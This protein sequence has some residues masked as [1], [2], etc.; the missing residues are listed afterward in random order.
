M[1]S[2]KATLLATVLILGLAIVFGAAAS[3]LTNRTAGAFSAPAQKID[4]QVIYLGTSDQTSSIVAAL[5][6]AS[7]AFIQTDDPRSLARASSGTVVYVD[8]PWYLAHLSN[9]AVNNSLSIVL[10]SGV[11]VVEVLPF[12]QSSTPFLPQL[13]PGVESMT[14]ILKEG[15]VQVSVTFL[16]YGLKVFPTSVGHVQYSV[17]YFVADSSNLSSSAAWFASDSLSW[18]LRETGNTPPPPPSGM[19]SS[20]T[21]IAAPQVVG[22]DNACVSHNANQSYTPQPLLAVGDPCPISGL[23]QSFVKNLYLSWDLCDTQGGLGYITANDNLYVV[24]NSGSNTYNFYVWYLWTNEVPGVL[25]QPSGC[26]SNWYGAD[27]QEQIDAG[28]YSGIYIWCYGPGT[29]TG[30][31]T[32]GVDVGFSAGSSGASASL[33]YSYSYSISDA[34]V[35]DQSNPSQSVNLLHWWTDL[36]EQ[37]SSG[38]NTFN[39]YPAGT[40]AVP[41]GSSTNLKS[42]WQ[43]ARWAQPGWC[44]WFC[45]ETLSSYFQIYFGN[46]SW[47]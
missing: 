9:S 45:G 1:N 5:K 25:P 11:P 29:T 22:I 7:Y 28:A 15:G 21:K 40:F 34:P 18:G 30:T 42:I 44:G 36:N 10:Q 17:G 27:I 20:V 14:P 43:E 39:S 2:R 19:L 35:Y 37:G 23:A 6:A 8:K 47:S 31:T 4:V 26:G 13:T 46:P 38:S 12:Y 24:K 33:G 41:I 32:A 16:G 3:S